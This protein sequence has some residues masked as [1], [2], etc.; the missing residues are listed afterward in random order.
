MT[1][2]LVE[3]RDYYREGATMVFT[4][5]FHLRRGVCCGSKCRHCPFE[6]ENV[7]GVAPKGH[8]AS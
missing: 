7:A 2:R 8:P 5:A 4:A 3:G 1:E 6:H